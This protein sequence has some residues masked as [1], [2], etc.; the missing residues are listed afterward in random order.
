MDG[1]PVQAILFL[2]IIPALVFLY[3]SLKGYEGYYKDKTVFLTFIFGIIFGIIS[4][5]L[6]LVLSAPPLMFL[7]LVLYSFFEQ[8]LK[9]IVLNIGRF[10]LK[11]ETTIYG[12]SLGLGFGSSFTPFLVIVESMSGISNTYYLSLIA[13]G[14]IGFILFHAASGALIG[15]GIYSGKLMRYLVIAI[16]LQIPFNAIA[17]G[18]RIISI[19]S[20]YLFIQFLLVSYGLII[21][22]YV[23]KKIIP[24]IL[25]KK[26]K[27]KRNKNKITR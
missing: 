20:Y 1:P 27:V 24:R 4:A 26:V 17:D 21:F 3:V 14:S 19:R 2:G 8:L 25:E 5:L 9:V 18:S 15:F 6:R 22:W 23:L 12:L 13:I 11:K 7:F 16:I 10:H